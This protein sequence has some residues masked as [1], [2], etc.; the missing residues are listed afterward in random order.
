[1]VAL[2]VDEDEDDELEVES[3]AVAEDARE[4]TEVNGE[5]FA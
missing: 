3:F 1:M 5:A 4:E 2:E